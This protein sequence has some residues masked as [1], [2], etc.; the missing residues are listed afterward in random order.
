M[1]HL[2]QRTGSGDE[3]MSFE[4]SLALSLSLSLYAVQLSR[5]KK[6]KL[7]KDFVL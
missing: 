5:W 2:F 1:V 3:K 6:K 4:C 7:N